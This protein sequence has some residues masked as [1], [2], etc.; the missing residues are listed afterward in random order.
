MKKE[1]EV[2]GQKVIVRTNAEDAVAKLQKLKLHERVA[3]GGRLTDAE[4]DLA[5]LALLQH[6]GIIEESGS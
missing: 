6:S 1:V 5:L 2:I 3:A 4:R